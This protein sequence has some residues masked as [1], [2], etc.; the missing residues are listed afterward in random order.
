MNEKTCPFCGASNEDGSEKCAVCGCDFK[1]LPPDLSLSASDESK[2]TQVLDVEG[3]D[4]EG[5]K[6]SKQSSNSSIPSWI[7]DRLKARSQS[8]E[9]TQTGASSFDTYMNALFGGAN[10]GEYQ[11]SQN[12]NTGKIETELPVSKMEAI[13]EPSILPDA[14]SSESEEDAPLN[15]PDD[16]TVAEGSAVELQT[17]D[18]DFSV[19]RPARKWDD[20]DSEPE[21]VVQSDS[22]ESAE[23]SSEKSEDQNSIV[24]GPLFE[25]NDNE[26]ESAVDDDE[27]LKASS[28]PGMFEEIPVPSISADDKSRP[29]GKPAD[30]AAQDGLQRDPVSPELP[31][32]QEETRED[33]ENRLPTI[34]P[35][36]ILGNFMNAFDAEMK[37]EE[38][39]DSQAEVISSEKT[40]TFFPDSSREELDS[41]A[42]TEAEL[43]DQILTNLSYTQE[44]HL[45]NEESETVESENTPKQG[46]ESN[47]EETFE[48]I[49]TET[50][51]ETASDENS[52][53]ADEVETI[54]E[55]ERDQIPWNLFESSGRLLPYPAEQGYRTFSRSGFSSEPTEVDYQQR[56]ISVLLDKIIRKENQNPLLEKPKA[57][58]SGK[59]IQVL[60]S[61]IA[62]GVTILILEGFFPVG[63]TL[64]P[65]IETTLASNAFTAFAAS[66]VNDGSVTIAVDMD[67]A[68]EQEILPAANQLIK[69]FSEQG[70][71]LQFV[72]LNPAALSVT[73][74][75]AEK[76]PDAVNLG[77]IPGNAAAISL[78]KAANKQ[79]P[80]LM[81]ILSANFITVQYWIEQMAVVFPE[82]RIGVIGSSQLSMLLS[83]YEDSGLIDASISTVVDRSCYAKTDFSN[84]MNKR[85]MFAVWGLIL[86]LVLALLAGVIYRFFSHGPDYSRMPHKI[87][88]TG[89]YAVVQDDGKTA[90][91][92]DK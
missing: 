28:A 47:T 72:T 18:D 61:L 8:N 24:E 1:A 76:T 55:E 64:K 31:F 73:N 40:T 35:G 50:E 67:P 9:H 20:P 12:K 13:Q 86:L 2:T 45:D 21:T 7:Q 26:E 5:K 70:T 56:M 16:S 3:K 71:K 83:P 78:L 17:V 89:V 59:L 10:V 33:D 14:G 69:Q 36:T 23:K 6:D 11:P 29:G 42:M 84:E 22:S 75:F 65:V 88:S 51:S 80:V 79:Q 77:Y 49:K 92:E 68:Y 52:E 41:G 37:E 54:E 25:L 32:E 85:E 38:T 81:V 34:D 39:S 91:K 74:Q 30:A 48:T 87:S 43:L 53:E 90:Q 4:V 60:F 27:M 62:I 15:E 58:Y 57:R 82:T 46:V 44:V 19:Q 66:A 63:I